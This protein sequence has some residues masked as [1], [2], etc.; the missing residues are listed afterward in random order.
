V[1]IYGI[2]MLGGP[3]DDL[4]HRRMYRATKGTLLLFI[5]WYSRPNRCFVQNC[6]YEL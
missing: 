1:K 3:D 4:V 6:S 2:G 5:V